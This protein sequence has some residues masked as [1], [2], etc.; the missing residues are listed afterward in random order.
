M[1]KLALLLLGLALGAVT[2]CKNTRA[3][4]VAPNRPT[5]QWKLYDETTGKLLATTDD[6]RGQTALGGG[7]SFNTT[8][9]QLVREVREAAEGSAHT[10]GV[11]LLRMGRSAALTA[12]VQKVQE[13]QAK[14][15]E[16]AQRA[17][18]A[19]DAG[20]EQDYLDLTKEVVALGKDIA[21]LIASGQESGPSGDNKSTE[22]LLLTTA[23]GQKEMILGLGQFG[24]GALEAEKGNR[25]TFIQ[26]TKTTVE[27]TTT[28]PEALSGIQAARDVS[29]ANL[30][31]QLDRY[32]IDAAR[33]AGGASP[34][35]LIDDDAS[36]ETP[37]APVKQTAYD[38]L[39]ANAKNF[40]W[41][42]RYDQKVER[43]TGVVFVPGDRP[44]IA[45][46]KI[47]F[48]DGSTQTP[49]ENYFAESQERQRLTFYNAYPA[50]PAKLVVTYADGQS[51]TYDIPDAHQR[52]QFQ[53]GPYKGAAPVDPAPAP[54]PAPVPV[55]DPANGA[56]AALTSA[57]ALHL[58]ADVA[59]LVNRVLVLSSINEAAN[60]ADKEPATRAG[61]TWAGSK[62]I[63][64]YAQPAVFQI[65]F[66]KRP[67]EDVPVHLNFVG[68]Y[69]NVGHFTAA[70]Q[71]SPPTSR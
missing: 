51:E 23:P 29:L 60:T 18:A 63:A 47:A 71:W 67:P 1:K 36:D 58:R 64:D 57:G 4:A 9:A 44:K 10:N 54:A 35:Q 31:A 26:S 20:L 43:G 42:S 14:R 39:S 61:N 17:I 30:W 22:L 11:T 53:P 66:S 48:K 15:K 8:D 50:G 25:P 16:T 34:D 24:Q 62:P 45:S 46:A 59:A 6:N 21:E 32:R 19:L 69:T 28:E 65:F 7:Q 13:L 55:A 3:P 40:L 33:K 68:G 27:D 2:G 41:K 56:P 5:A 38:K 37:A 49:R 52:R 70:S 12:N